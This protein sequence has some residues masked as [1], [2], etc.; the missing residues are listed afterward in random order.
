MFVTHLSY[1]SISWP[2][3]EPPLGHPGGNPLKHLPRIVYAHPRKNHTDDDHQ[4]WSLHSKDGRLKKSYLPNP[5][6]LNLGIAPLR[7]CRFMAEFFK[8]Y[9]KGGVRK[10]HWFDARCFHEKSWGLEGLKKGN[11]RVEKF[12]RCNK[13]LV[14]EVLSKNGTRKMNLVVG[15]V[16]LCDDQQTSETSR[17]ELADASNFEHPFK[18]SCLFERSH[19][20]NIAVCIFGRLQCASL[21]WIPTRT[22]GSF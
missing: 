17:L 12:C 9:F 1:I 14:L 3:L 6:V 13:Q 18:H 15:S 8:G 5:Q 20:C 21:K 11:W 7:G 10:L 2:H 16:V 22:W 19:T 4:R